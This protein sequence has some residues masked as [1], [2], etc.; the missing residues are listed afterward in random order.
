MGAKGCYFQTKTAEG[1]CPGY[2]VKPIDTTGYG[3]AFF[4]ALL[5]GIARAQQKVDAFS[6]ENLKS[7]CVYAN[8][9]GALTSLKLGGAG[10]VPFAKDVSRFLVREHSSC[11]G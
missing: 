8:A 2:K 7:I 5:H 1:F 4:A 9:V 3:D 10:G 6:A 11:G